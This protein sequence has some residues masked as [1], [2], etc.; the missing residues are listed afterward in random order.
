[1]YSSAKK[2]AL[3]IFA[4]FFFS[5]FSSSDI[6]LAQTISY[7]TE[8]GETFSI[9]SCS[10]V[11]CNT[12]CDEY[13]CWP[14]C[15][16]CTQCSCSGTWTEYRAQST[17]CG[18]EIL[19]RT[20]QSVCTAGAD[21]CTCGGCTVECTAPTVYQTCG[22]WQ[23]TE[24]NSCTVT[25]WGLTAPYC[26]CKGSCI[27]TPGS[28]P[29]APNG[30]YYY[31]NR[32]FPLNYCSPEASLGNS[33]LL[34]PIKF[35]WTNVRGWESGWCNGATVTTCSG[36]H[37]ANELV[38]YYLLEMTENSSGNTIFSFDPATGKLEDS[39][40]I[41]N[42]CTLKSDDSY[43]WK[44]KACCEENAV[45]AGECGGSSSWSFSTNPA[46]EPVSPDDPD[47]VGAGK[48]EN[49]AVPALL[50]WCNISGAQTYYLELFKDGELY[51]PWIVEKATT[52]ASPSVE[53]LSSETILSEEILT[54]FRDYTWKVSWCETASGT[55][56]GPICSANEEGIECANF[57]QAWQFKTGDVL[58][59]APK[60]VSP[61]STAGT[62]V[63]N[64]YD[65]LQWE[66]LDQYG[67]ESFRYEIFDGAN[68]IF[69]STSE[70][71]SIIPFSLIWEELEYD[72]FYT[73]TIR[74]CWD[75][76]GL[77][78]DPQSDQDSF[79]TTGAVPT[80][81]QPDANP[82]NGALNVPFPIDL[83]WDKMPGAASYRYQISNDSTFTNI[84][85][86][87]VVPTSAISV[88]Y[89][90]L[91]MGTQ[92]WWRVRTCADHEG[93]LCGN[94][95]TYNF[96]TILLTPPVNL[97]PGNAD[98]GS[99]TDVPWND[100]VLKFDQENGAV[101][102]WYSLEATDGSSVIDE[103]SSSNIIKAY[104]DPING[105]DKVYRWQV[106]ACID[107]TA[108]KID[109]PD[110]CSSWSQYYY[111]RAV[112]PTGVE[113]T[114]LLPCG[115]LVDNP[116]TP[117]NER[118]SCQFSDFFLLIKVIL[119]F[120]MWSLVPIILILEALITGIIFYLSKQMGSLSTID[121]VKT[122]WKA[123]GIG[124]GIIFFAWI[125]ITLLMAVMGYQTPVFGNWWQL[126]L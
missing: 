119:N 77:N 95:G 94:W 78:C 49:V 36:P 26:A 17:N 56:C 103:K 57:S 93:N 71:A 114:G 121:T 27:D 61:T 97:S 15:P 24:R 60:I 79:I 16:C 31:N 104:I 72:H 21:C 32:T 106:R 112:E 63:V 76:E 34:L 18:T 89:P 82:Q 85:K 50:D 42:S 113:K 54:K 101:S 12:C 124:I 33:N 68:L 55:K 6:S 102:Y 120:A 2:F 98:P 80:L 7:S 8:C 48:I 70:S 20:C 126:N 64:T 4:V 100:V 38:G 73:W 1:M 65:K 37:C 108:T 125:F 109:S 5:F 67:E 86:E 111:F 59:P 116:D 29:S 39:Y 35:D 45:H 52:T 10:S 11:Y 107:T 47:W 22:S 88:G 41:P 92:Y 46:P 14:C 28:T 81:N 9:G 44:V 51:Y 115:R 117:W 83:N 69:A 23:I 30:A 84:V 66:R 3:I 40:K 25:S 105:V 62:P 90:D 123:T 75:T 53:I 87:E 96:T 43:A 122:I 74:S 118:K 13:S 19:E 110:I 99:P 91:I 58:L